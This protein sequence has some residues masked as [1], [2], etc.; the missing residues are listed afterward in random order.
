[1]GT[2]VVTLPDGKKARVTF[3][4]QAQLDA[5][6]ND[7]VKQHP[8]R[9]TQ[10]EKFRPSSPLDRVSEA[11]G[12]PAL[13]MATGAAGAAVGGVEGIAR[14]IG[15]GAASLAQGEGLERARQ[16]FADEAT[17]TI[18]QREQQLTRQPRTATG[19]AAS[20]VVSAPFTLLSKAGDV[21]G[22]K[23]ADVTGSPALGAAVN[24]A[25]QA[26]PGFILPG[27][28]A[29]LR[30][31]RAAG[32]Q[33]SASG[34]PRAAPF[35]PG[36]VPRDVPQPETAGAQPG[37]TAAQPGATA[38]PG[39]GQGPGAAPGAPGAAPGRPATPPPMSATEQRAAA[40][41]R[42]IG[43]DWTRLA[44]GTRKALTTIAQDA[45]ALERLKPA[46]VRR[47]AHLA[48]LRVPV[49][50]TRGQLTQDPV[51][52]RRE[53]VAATTSSGEPIRDIDTAANRDI[54]ANLEVLRGRLA[55]RRG[56]L[57]EAADTEG[58]VREGLVRSPT[59]APT[60][61]GESVQGAA[62]KQAAASKRNYQQLYKKARE[63]E[64]DAKVPIAPVIELLSSNPE[65]QHLGWVQGWLS[66]AAKITES[67]EAPSDVTLNE[68]HDLRS[69]AND[70][71]RT[72][73]KEGHYAGQVVKAIDAAM[74]SAPEGAAAWRAA[75]KAFREHQAQFKDQ[76]IIGKLVSQK[77]GG[78]DR[79][80]ALEK[81][82]K[83]I[84]G[85]PLEQIR[86]VKETLLRTGSRENRIAG[87][88]AWAD[89]RA[90]TVNRILED[91]RNVTS[92]DPAE[93]NLLTA[94]ALQRSIRRIP[95]QNLEELIGKG[96]TRE[97]YDILRAREIT[98]GRTTQSGTVPNL[99][100]MAEKIVSHLP[101]AGKYAAGAVKGLRKLG[102]LGEGAKA[103]ERAAVS[104]LEETARDVERLSRRRAYRA[105]L[106]TLERAGP[107]LPAATP[108][109]P[110]IGDLIQRPPP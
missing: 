57:E 65:I 22:R 56:S 28:R 45:Q 59:K 73:G 49:R 41:A 64:P 101:V 20:E 88:K 36:D 86:Q 79:S 51:E 84:S 90:E 39:P 25:I 16:A 42:S 96:A 9:E 6:V 94:A 72:G 61:V 38:A 43:L 29:A 89:L 26:A 71:A 13:Q 60:E 5:T 58:N 24:T 21:A 67:G 76:G 105:G 80:L 83:T 31:S 93:R 75:N 33:L 50:A 37:A 100:V 107:T 66:K 54:Q 35:E 8:S 18:H 110:T 30:A 74:E 63:T 1:M 4:D 70:I 95:R 82:W 104:P 106:E 109:S 19:K 98:R 55:G 48:S 53:A 69:T 102:E 14:G 87:A 85:G 15:A 32:A 91:A 46:D 92:K 40:Y 78:A 81:T 68:L 11:V 99:L 77:K 44:V 103:A 47:Q 2:A 27:A 108:Q 17:D 34:A 62:R 12:E 52:L 10:A 97:L 3:T 7:L 23:V